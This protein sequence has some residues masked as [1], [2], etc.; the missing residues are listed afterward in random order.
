MIPPPE[1][2]LTETELAS[3]FSPD[4]IVPCIRT[5]LLLDHTGMKCCETR[6]N[7]TRV[8]SP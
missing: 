3:H 5:L 6:T 2:K 4:S 7:K 1:K 8:L